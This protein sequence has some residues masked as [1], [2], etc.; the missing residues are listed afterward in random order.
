MKQNQEMLTKNKSESIEKELDETMLLALKEAKQKGASSW[1]TV[2]PLEE[3]DFVLSK[4]EFRDAINLRYG[5]NL[6]G[7]PSKC[8]CGQNYNVN[9]ALNCK[10]GGTARKV[11]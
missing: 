2:L 6:C 8:P 3:Y 5:K 4:A 1:L 11:K 10:N 9:H 7:L